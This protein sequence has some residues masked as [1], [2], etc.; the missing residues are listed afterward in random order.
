MAKKTFTFDISVDAWINGLEIEAETYEE[1]LAALN[2]LR[3]DEIID[4]GYVK[5]FAIKDLDYDV[6]EDYLEEEDDYDYNI[7][8]EYNYREKEKIFVDD[9]EDDE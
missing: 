9:T 4:D 3:L 6:E 2:D 8:D 1:A 5:S 7:D